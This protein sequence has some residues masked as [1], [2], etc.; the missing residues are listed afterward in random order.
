MIVAIYA[1]VSTSK[2]AEK[3]LSIPDQIRQMEDWCKNHGHQ[4]GMVY[5]EPGAS[6]TDDRRPVFQQMIAEACVAERPFEGIVVHSLSRFFRDCIEFGLYERRLRKHG[7]SVISIS[8]QTSDD[9]AGE[10]ARRIFSV[11]DEYQSKENGKHTLR[12]MR[13]NA[14]QGFF[15]GSSPLF[16]YRTVEVDLPGRKGRKKRLTVDPSEAGTVRR[17]FDLYLNG[18]GRRALGVKGIAIYLNERGILRRGKRW[19]KSTVYQLLE[20]RAYIGEHIF[21][22]KDHKTGRLKPESEWVVGHVEAILDKE[23]FEKCAGL[24]ERRSPAETPPRVVKSP[25]LLTGLLKCGL[26]GSAMTLGTGKGGLYRYYKCS[27]RINEGAGACLSHN[28]RMEKLDRVVLDAL[29]EKVFTPS[30]VRVMMKELKVAVEKKGSSISGDLTS[31]K[32]ELEDTAQRLER[33]YEAVEK[34]VLPV[35]MSLQERAQKHK[36]RREEIL[37]E[38]ARLRGKKEMPLKAL[39]TKHVD[40]FCSALKVK[41]KDRSS[42]LGKEYLRLLVDEIRVEGGEVVMKGRHTPIAGMIGGKKV[43][44]LERVPTFAVDWLPGTDSNCRPSG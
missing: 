11:F 3:D 1:R 26:C 21:N 10:M 20:N 25:T 32:R 43:G 36:A 24:R 28:I 19:N 16:G 34:G 13:E 37:V 38:M 18:D 17:I 42:S 8:Q 27:K 30:R 12:A 4:V 31:L 35:D 29:G 39:S 7:V 22:R 5:S 41:L 40:S 33:L 44:A 6:A 14:R 9:P 15:N 23:I 2:Q